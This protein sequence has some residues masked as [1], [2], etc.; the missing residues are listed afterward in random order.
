MV[1]KK[2]DNPTA[3]VFAYARVS[4]RAQITDRQEVDHARQ[5]REGRTRPGAWSHL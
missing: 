1:S 5:A 2:S 3:K 4:T